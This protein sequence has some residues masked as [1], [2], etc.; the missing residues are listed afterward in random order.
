MKIKISRP[1]LL[2]IATLIKKLLSNE[3]ISKKLMSTVNKI[4]TH[5]YERVYKTKPVSLKPSRQ[6][7]SLL[8]QG[9]HR[10][11]FKKSYMFPKLK[12]LTF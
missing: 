3:N 10:V 11:R 4:K 7:S 12:E 8:S 1:K 5:V 6:S 2:E 9:L